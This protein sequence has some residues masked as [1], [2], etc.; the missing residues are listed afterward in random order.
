[1]S[2][3]TSRLRRSTPEQTHVRWQLYHV[4]GLSEGKLRVTQA[5]MRDL[6]NQ[7]HQDIPI[8]N[9]KKNKERAA[10]GQGRWADPGLSQAVRP[11]LRFRRAGTRREGRLIYREVATA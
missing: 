5:R 2:C 7:I 4:P 1:M 8:W 9:N 6:V 3:M 10:A 11:L